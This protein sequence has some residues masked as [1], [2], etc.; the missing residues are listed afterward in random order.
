[1]SDKVNKN[2]DD[3]NGRI[4][5]FSQDP[6]FYVKRGDMKRAQNDLISAISMYNEALEKDPF[7]FDTRLSA[8]EVL[9][10]MARFNDSNRMLI[11]YMHLDEEF[12]KDAYCMV[13]FNLMG[14][15]E[16]EG[17]KACFDRFFELTDEVSERTD[18]IL[19]AIDY[20]ESLDT[21]E[22]AL[23]DAAVIKRNS[24]IRRAHEAFNRG[25][26]EEASNLFAQLYND[27]PGD[28]IIIYQLALS[29]LCCHREEEGAGYL[30]KLI[31]SDGNNWTALSLKLMYA[32]GM[33]NEIEMTQV[34][35]KLEK[36]D[37]EQPDVLLRVNGALIEAGSFEAAARIAKRLVKLMPYD[38]LANHRLAVSYMRSKD[39]P[40]A[41][42]VYGKLLRIDKND[43]IAKYYR[44]AC[45]KAETD[46]SAARI[47]EKAIIHYQL[48]VESIIVRAKSLLA[49]RDTSAEELI[50]SWKNDASF[51]E[52]VRWAFTLNEF[53]VSYA[54]L[55][56][57][58][59]V[60]DDHSVRL[61]REIMSDIETNRAIVNE[62]MGTL[63]RM[64]AAEPFFAI[65]DGSLL[66]GRVN[67]IDLSNVKIPH[68][69]AG[70]FPRFSKKATPYYSGEVISTGANI[71]ERFL[72]NLKGSF[73]R[74]SEDQSVAL[75]AALEI[76]A[77]DQCGA[78]VCTDIEERYGV[79]KRRLMNAIDR[80]VKTVISG[81]TDSPDGGGD[82]E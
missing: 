25:D 16:L 64:G 6:A 44:T 68:T 26:Y 67:I 51:R 52:T 18:A 66:E 38:S 22:P 72:A 56:L 24:D 23:S 13:G 39:F 29:C 21:D 74:I 70:I 75:S 42:K 82:E 62:A 80:I 30:E 33:N 69:Y 73:P 48:P 10:D 15:S 55:S 65:M 61:I 14:L 76:L 59:M 17:A 9:T 53:N 54:M 36:C 7:D 40:N 71:I 2:K 19:D 8:A 46:P 32:K 12:K 37:S 1:M 78:E 58:R 41:A 60:K 77:C 79:S 81:L 63:K 47:A 4:L 49:S 43:Y 31:E 34:A 27:K 45:I 57:L 50:E 20:I 3:A 35:K 5:H 28:S 11:P